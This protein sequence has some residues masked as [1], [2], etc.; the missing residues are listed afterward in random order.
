MSYK[1]TYIPTVNN[2]DFQGMKLG[3]LKVYVKKYYNENIKN[4]TVTNKHK[5]ITVK[6]S[7]KGID[8]L[9]YAR[10]AGFVKLKAVLKLKEI[11]ENAVFLNFKDKDKSDSKD[12]FGYINMKCKV[13]IEEKN[14]VFRIVIKLTKDGKF[15]Y[16]HSVKVRK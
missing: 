6:F 16:D 10:N 12:I 15:Y 4:T 13:N 14:Q 5:N 9:L 7:R 1:Q 3:E 2:K 11:V 8:H